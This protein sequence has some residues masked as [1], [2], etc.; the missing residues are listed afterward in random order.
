MLE[1]QGG[2][3][4]NVLD[5]KYK[6]DDRLKISRE[7]DPPPESM[8]IAIGFNQTADEKNRHYRRYYPDELENISEAVGKK[9]FNEFKLRKGAQRGVKP[10]LFSMFSKPKTDDSGNISTVKEVGYFK[11]VVKVHNPDQKDDFMATKLA[12]DAAVIDL[13][14]KIYKRR[15]GEEMDLNVDELESQEG[16][17]KF[18]GILKNM[19]CGHLDIARFLVET[20]YEDLMAKMM[21]QKTKCLIRVY[22]IEGFD[23]AQ[24]DIGSASDPYLILSCGKKK[25]N[26]QDNYQLDEPN[27]KFHT[28]YDFDATFPGA[29]PLEIKAMDYD[30]LFGDDL[31][32]S[33]TID[34]DDRFFSPHWQSIRDKPIEYR[35]IY[36]PSSTVA[37]GVIKLWVEIHPTTKATADAQ[38]KDIRPRPV[39]KYEMRMVVWDTVDVVAKDAEGTSD[40]Y[41]RTFFD[42]KKQTRETDCHYRCSNG[43]ASFNYRLLFDIDAPRDDQFLFT[44][45]LWDRDLFA[46]NDMIGEAQINLDAIVNDV[47]ESGKQMSINKK[48]YDSY[49]KEHLGMKL[50]FKDEDSFYIPCR[51]MND[52]NEMEDGGKVRVSITIMPKDM[53]DLNKVGDAR[54]EPN[55]SPFCPPPVGRISFSLN[56]FK[57]L[58]QLVGPAV[59]RKLY[60]MCCLAICCALFIMMLPMI[61]SNMVSGMVSKLIMG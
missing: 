6:Y 4:S 45:Q 40:V 52:K 56:P 27:P 39:K 43:K 55:H 31:I 13:V 53:A 60:C 41:A 44:M 54:S 30:D 12:R 21:T 20:K 9:P 10:G 57:M 11:G 16:K 18:M 49:L 32:G 61:A 7:V 22:V 47:V 37:Q 8:F 3:H 38:P 36:V 1:N 35:Q 51:M 24:R 14:K 25:F 28:H 34:L 17:A 5:P 59:L 15:F 42:S 50:D 23:F 46:S 19:G 33:T 58:S 29:P 26:D 2:N 48:Y